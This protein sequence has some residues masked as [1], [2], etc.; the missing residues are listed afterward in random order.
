MRT[1]SLL[2]VTLLIGAA[3]VAG[4][5]AQNAPTWTYAP[6]VDGGYG[7]RE[8][9]A[10]T[11]GARIGSAR[12]P[13]GGG[14]RRDARDQRLRPRL[15][16]G[17]AERRR[18]RPLRGRLHQ[19]RRHPPRH[20]VRRRRRW[21]RR[22]PAKQPRSRSTCRPAASRSSARSRVTSRRGMKGSVTVD[23]A[24]PRAAPA[25]D[26]HGGPMPE[27]DVAADPERARAPS[28]TT[29]AAPKR[30]DGTVH[31]IDLVITEKQMT[32]AARLCPEGLDI[33]WDGPG[34]GHP[35]QGRRHHPRPPEEPGRE[36]AAPIRSTSTPARSPGT[37]R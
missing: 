22:T 13:C 10:S 5:S 30:L 32:V 8:P 18:T 34:S 16:A 21:P 35:G 27:T 7:L 12:G 1:R 15:R 36:R 25:A 33:R 29:P 23:G 14:R 28:P 4:C 20:H 24:R 9:V 3:L 11:C 19:H 17:A 31:D 2:P 26:D 6:N 37:T